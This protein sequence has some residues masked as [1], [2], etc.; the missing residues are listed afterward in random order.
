MFLGEGFLVTAHRGAVPVIDSMAA[1]A[2][3]ALARGA[4]WLL[5]G[6]LDRSVDLLFPV[7]DRLS[8]QL[9][10]IQDSLLDDPVQG[11]LQRLYANKRVKLIACSSKI[12]SIPACV[13]SVSTGHNPF[14]R[15]VLTWTIAPWA[16][17]MVMKSCGSGS[18]PM[19]NMRSYSSGYRTW[20]KH[21]EAIIRR[22]FP[23]N[24]NCNMRQN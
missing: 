9:D 18:D 13:L 8:D 4:D 10:A 23:L 15:R 24:K 5:H 19:I 2:A 7:V 16:R 3:T 20:A 1:E 6:M 14:T 22:A 12:P 17:W 21:S 11:D